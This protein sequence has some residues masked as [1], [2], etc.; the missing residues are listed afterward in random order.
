ML[1]A[2]HN[3][4]LK[5]PLVQLVPE[6]LTQPEDVP[7][8]LRPLGGEQA[9][10]LPVPVRLDEAERQVLQAPLEVPD[11]QPV[12]QRRVDVQG[13]PGD[14]DALLGRVG[15]ERLHVVKAVRQLDQHHAYVLGRGH[16]HLAK[17][18]RLAVVVV[19]ARAVLRVHQV[20][21]AQLGN[22]VH[23][24]CDLL[25]ELPA[26]VVVGDVAV[27]DHVVEESGGERGGVQVQLRQEH[28]RAD[29]VHHVGLARQ[30]LLAVVRVAGK[31]EGVL[32]ERKP[33]GRQ[34]AP[35][36]R[37]DVL[38]GM[39]LVRN[40]RSGHA[41]SIATRSCSCKP[42]NPSFTLLTNYAIPLKLLRSC[43]YNPPM[44]ISDSVETL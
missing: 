32:D 21:L 23:Q 35:R 20:H 10:D 25:P 34:I 22:P 29:G 6:R 33:I 3:L 36:L 12:G 27:L 14:G 11:A 8:P 4:R 7:L 19:V 30:P 24:P 41:E 9:R 18:A 44:R 13:L 16:Q 1:G 43:I 40:A 31:L 42:R 28:G 5:S 26:Q 38:G 15:A 2:A 39:Y 17:A 37:Q